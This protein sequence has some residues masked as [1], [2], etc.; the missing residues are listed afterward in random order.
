MALLG[1]KRFYK[2]AKGLPLPASRRITR[3]RS[4]RTT[5]LLVDLEALRETVNK[6]IGSGQSTCE[7]AESLAENFTE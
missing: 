5:K 6:S 2:T 1:A 4:A 3:K 7:N